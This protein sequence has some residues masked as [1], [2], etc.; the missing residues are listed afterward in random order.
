MTVKAVRE[1]KK[2]ML[3]IFKTLANRQQMQI[4]IAGSG[5]FINNNGY[6]VTTAHLFDGA[7]PQTQFVYWGLL[8]ENR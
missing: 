4:A 6:V 5:F 2:G 3:P 8:P 1:I 7:T